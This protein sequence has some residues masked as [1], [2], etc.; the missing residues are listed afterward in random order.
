MLQAH[1]LSTLGVRATDQHQP[2]RALGERAGRIAEAGVTDLRR[3]MLVDG[4]LTGYGLF[5]GSALEA[6]G[7][8][9]ALE[10]LIHPRD[11]RTGLT[12]SLLPMIHAI[13]DDLLSPDEAAHHLQL[14]SDHLLGP[15]GAR[16][17]DRPVRLR[18][19]PDDAVPAGR[20]QHV[21]RS[22]DRDHVHARAPALRRG[23]RPGRRRPGAAEG[24]G[25]GPA[26]RDDRSGRRRQPRQ[27]TCYYS[28][29]DAAFADRY[30]ADDGYHGIFDGTVPL[31]GG[32]RIYSSG[33]G[34]FLQLLVQH[35]L[36]LRPQGCRA[37]HRSRARS[38]PGRPRRTGSVARSAAHDPVLGRAAEATASGRSGPE[39][40]SW[41]RHHW[42]TRTA[43]AAYRSEWT[44]SRRASVDPDAVVEIVTQ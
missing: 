23:A 40:P 34:L 14:I 26:D 15:D 12:Y 22:R 19:R 24:D 42:P 5:G 3:L 8:D 16:L 2:T 44:T 28:S 13:A 29:S 9:G 39:A 32:W 18:R 10:P 21:L 4:V 37:A 43:A 38:G 1:A 20:G 7:P 30:A 35:Q 31:E 41:R 33:P 27:S 6:D 36:G 11:V 25:P 17:F